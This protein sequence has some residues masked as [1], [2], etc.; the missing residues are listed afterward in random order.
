MGKF[1]LK[2]MAKSNIK[3]KNFKPGS[4]KIFR[5]RQYFSWSTDFST[6]KI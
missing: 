3:N 6:T 4:K 5:G 2:R 1:K